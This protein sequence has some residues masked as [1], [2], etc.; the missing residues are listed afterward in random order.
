MEKIEGSQ[1]HVPRIQGSHPAARWR[2]LQEQFYRMVGEECRRCGNK[3]FPPRDVC[4]ECVRPFFEDYGLLER[5]L[6]PKNEE[7][8]EVEIIVSQVEMAGVM[9]D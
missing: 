9:G 6:E 8:L 7:V 5:G 2:R 1:P 3:I 4:P